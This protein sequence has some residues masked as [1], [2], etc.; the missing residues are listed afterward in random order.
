MVLTME[1][2]SSWFHFD[3]LADKR[4]AWDVAKDYVLRIVIKYHELVRDTSGGLCFL[5]F[6]VGL[7]FFHLLAWE[8]LLMLSDFS[9]RTVAWRDVS[10]DD[11][12]KV[13]VELFAYFEL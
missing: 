5:F 2:V 4:L 1:H 12:L 11:L 9:Q 13:L 7:H 10:L 3:E 6:E 8:E